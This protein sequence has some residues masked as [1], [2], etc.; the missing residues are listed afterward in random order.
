MGVVLSLTWL[1]SLNPLRI[2]PRDFQEA[3]RAHF[4]EFVADFEARQVQR[5]GRPVHLTPKAYQL[6]AMLVE[7]RPRAL[8]KRELQQGLWPSTFV[9]EA[10]LSV[11]VAELRAALGDDARHPRFVRTVHGYGYAFEAEVG[12]DRQVTADAGTDG[13]WWLHSRAIH[14]RLGDGEHLV[15]RELPI[16]IWLDSGSV[17]RRH[18]RVTVAGHDVWVEDLGSKNGT[19]VNGDRITERTGVTNGDELR[20]G[21]VAVRLHWAMAA[22]ST[23]TLGPIE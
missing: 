20:F 11:L 1:E 12:H 13:D 19:F 21:A 14:A 6:L 5:L 23:D 15:G 3:M 18:A 7:A 16:D 4:G 10:N 9:D 17:S 22:S 2:L 8:S